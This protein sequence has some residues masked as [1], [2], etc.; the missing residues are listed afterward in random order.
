MS[1]GWAWE[2]AKRPPAGNR[3]RRL[4]G[5]QVISVSGKVSKENRSRLSQDVFLLGL[6]TLDLATQGPNF[7]LFILPEEIP[8]VLED[9]DSDLSCD[10]LQE[11]WEI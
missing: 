2:A 1:I 3:G 8:K 10:I 9:S 7:Y 6:Y 4:A 11:T 5:V